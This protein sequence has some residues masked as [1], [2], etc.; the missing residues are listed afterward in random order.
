MKGVQFNEAERPQGPRV[1]WEPRTTVMALEAGC[2]GHRLQRWVRVR[3]SSAPVRKL[4]F[5]VFLLDE[6]DM[7]GRSLIACR[8][9]V[10]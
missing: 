4:L 10:R 2:L 3:M 9:L 7:W 1:F 5:E 8:P 6:K